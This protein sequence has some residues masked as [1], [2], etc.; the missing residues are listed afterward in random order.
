M[1]IFII[2]DIIYIGIKKII[3]TILYVFKKIYKCIKYIFSCK[4]IK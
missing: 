3:N 2:I 4:C 1:C